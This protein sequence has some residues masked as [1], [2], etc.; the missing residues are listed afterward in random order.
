V[1]L[2]RPLKGFAP[3]PDELPGAFFVLE[4]SRDAEAF[5]L[6]V[7][8]EDR[9]TYDLGDEIADLQVLFRTRTN[10]VTGGP[11]QPELIDRMIDI[12]RELGMAQYIPTPGEL[13]EDRVLSIVPRE[14]PHRGLKFDEDEDQKTWLHGLRQRVGSR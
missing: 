7:D 10:A 13:V 2:L 14:A 4:F 5:R 3:V 8:D 6:H 9:S 1:T 11:L 12:A